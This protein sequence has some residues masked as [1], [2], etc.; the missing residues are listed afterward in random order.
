MISILFISLLFQHL[1]AEGINCKKFG[2]YCMACNESSCTS[3][4]WPSIRDKDTSSRT[5]GHCIICTPRCLSCLNQTHCQA[6]LPYFGLDEKG[7]CVPCDDSY[8][9]GCS[10][11]HSECNS[12]IDGYGFDKNESSSSYG[13]C[14]RA[15]APH[16]IKYNGYDKCGTCEDGYYLNYTSQTHRFEY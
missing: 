3:C 6:C 9:D 13:K 15:I 7:K 5:F 14:R 12:C 2:S 1:S 16:C 10:T 8:C 11:N 4:L